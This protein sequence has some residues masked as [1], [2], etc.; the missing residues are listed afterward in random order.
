MTE[1]R[2]IAKPDWYTSDSPQTLGAT[3]RP[4]RWGVVGTGNIAATVTEDLVL[5]EDAILHSVSSRSQAKV[6][7]FASRFGFASH[8]YDDGGIPGYQRLVQ[9]PEVDVVYIATPHAQHFT[10]A[11]AALE[12]GKHVL[13][14]KAFTINA[15]EA[16]ELIRLATERKLFLMEAVWARFVPGMQR[17]FDI[18]AS[19]EIGQ[20]QWVHA[21]LSFLVPDDPAARIW[22]PKD[23]GGA[24]LDLTMYPLLWACG[25]LG[26][27]QPVRA[28]GTLTELGVDSQNAITLAYSSGAQAQLMSSL[29]AVGPESA[30]VAGSK[31][32][33]QTVGSVNNPAALTVQTGRGDTRVETFEPVGSGYTYQLREVTRCIQQGLTESPTMPLADSLAIMH[34][35]DGIWAQLGVVYPNDA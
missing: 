13:C 12:A 1:P 31:G 19:G 26:A 32:F 3:G 16:A 29:T 6:A 5:L 22:A 20:V 17:S 23:G 14:E 33:L 27:P 11:K 8:Y 21:D 2:F 18:I 10:V 4:L 25:A 15:R 7:H 28:T 30:V 34:L 35:F 24:L 9:D